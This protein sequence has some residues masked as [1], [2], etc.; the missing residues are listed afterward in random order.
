MEDMQ[1]EIQSDEFRHKLEEDIRRS[2]EA[3]SQ[4]ENTP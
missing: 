3:P 4:P 2:E 1:K